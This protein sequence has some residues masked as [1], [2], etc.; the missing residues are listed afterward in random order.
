M[1]KAGRGRPLRFVGLVAA[2]WIGARVLLLWPA[3]ESAVALEVAAPVSAPA[4]VP[5]DRAN[6]RAVGPWP[7][8]GSAQPPAELLPARRPPPGVERVAASARDLQPRVGLFAV[9]LDASAEAMPPAVAIAVAPSIPDRLTPLPDRWSTSLWIVARAGTGIGAAPGAGQLGG[10]QAGLRV[11]WLAVPRARVAA[12]ARLTAPLAGAGREAALGVEWQPAARLPLRIAVERRFGLDGVAGG[13][14]IGMVGGGDTRIAGGF[15]LESYIQAG[16]VHR[17]RWEPYAD[18]AVRGL[19][20]AGDT[21]GA[22]LAFGAG[23]WGAAQRGVA[24][25]DLG[26]TAIVSVPV[27]QRMLRVTLDWR[28]RVAGQARPGSGLALTLGGDF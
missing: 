21:G 1:T 13:A 17:T 3:G 7:A 24:R 25:L 5:P 11:A 28:Q 2:T 20:T 26:P 10:G 23:A 18:G 6:R 19:R 15:R 9:G 8:A 22:R 12:V 27:A 16:A 14:G 4:R